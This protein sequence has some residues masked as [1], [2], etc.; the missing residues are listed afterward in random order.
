MAG[1]LGIIDLYHM[2][3]V[4]GG[5][6]GHGIRGMSLGVKVHLSRGYMVIKL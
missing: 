2:V 6:G 4:V 3:C 5:K 1:N